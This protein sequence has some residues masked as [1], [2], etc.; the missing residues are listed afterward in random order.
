VKNGSKYPVV[1]KG[2]GGDSP[3]KKEKSKKKKKEEK[4]HRKKTQ[5]QSKTFE[6]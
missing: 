1:G 4:Q 6:D 5:E 2:L 3:H